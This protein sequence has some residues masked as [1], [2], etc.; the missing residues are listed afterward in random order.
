MKMKKLN[1]LICCLPLLTLLSA[2]CSASNQAQ[3]GQVSSLP[4]ASGLDISESAES[5]GGEPL[6]P[7]ASEEKP[8]KQYLPKRADQLYYWD[9]ETAYEL[10]K[11]AYTA[12]DNAINIKDPIDLDLYISS[13]NKNLK[14]HRENQMLAYKYRDL[15]ERQNFMFCVSSCEF[16]WDESAHSVSTMRLDLVVIIGTPYSHGGEGAHF[17]VKID[18]ER[19]VIADWFVEAKDCYDYSTRGDFRTAEFGDP[20]IWNDE[21]WVSQIWEKTANFYGNLAY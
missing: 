15:H 6:L 13:S 19:L 9:F 21:E 2:S 5:S 14:K 11:D 17:I 12:L 3:S 16:I 7:V 10:C 18:G 1:S 20:E 8:Q 4:D